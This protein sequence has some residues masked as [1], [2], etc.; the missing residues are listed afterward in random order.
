MN[1]LRFLSCLS[2]LALLTSCSNPQIAPDHHNV[3]K[4]VIASLSTLTDKISLREESLNKS[5]AASDN[6]K[7][8][9][10]TPTPTEKTVALAEEKISVPD[11]AVLVKGHH[12]QALQNR[13]SQL[14]KNP[15]GI[16]QIA[17]AFY[18][19]VASGHSEYFI[20]TLKSLFS[21]ETTSYIL[22]CAY[23][24]SIATN[25][26]AVTEALRKIVN[27]LSSNQKQ[28]ILG[29]VLFVDSTYVHADFRK[30]IVAEADKLGLDDHFFNKSQE[31]ISGLKAT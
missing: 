22:A 2:L 19:F 26:T 18:P 29:Y 15:Q 9:E 12:D 10:I 16:Q 31:D 25:D 28:Q 1:L 27:Q 3:F 4:E 30:N 21:F 6:A 11:M 5:M 7:Q 8:N 17:Q 24:Q 20:K 23:Y 13:L 14:A